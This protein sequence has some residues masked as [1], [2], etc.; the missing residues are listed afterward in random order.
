[1]GLNDTINNLSAFRWISAYLNQNS[2][3]EEYRILS[4]RSKLMFQD[5]T[6]ALPEFSNPR[7]SRLSSETRGNKTKQLSA[8]MT[9]QQTEALRVV[10]LCV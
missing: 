8:D 4:A 7:H 3:Y 2:I 10:A 1:V 5:Q 6:F 9:S